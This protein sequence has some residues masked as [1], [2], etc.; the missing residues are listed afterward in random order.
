MKGVL[1]R[2]DLLPPE[3]IENIEE[4]FDTVNHDAMKEV[5]KRGILTGAGPRGQEVVMPNSLSSLDDEQLGDLLNQVSAWC[6]FLEVELGKAESNYRSAQRKLNSMK[7]RIRITL[8][9]DEEGKKLTGPDKDDRVGCDPRVSG[10]DREEL[11]HYTIYRI[12]KA[13]RDQAQMNWE[14]VSRRITI[15]GQ[16]VQRMKRESNVAGVPTHGRTFN[17]RPSHQ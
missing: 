16:E 2:L 12:T 15:R 9:I 14:T 7:A 3:D 5:Y 13:A 17:R 6:G 8:K 4:S 11:F 10:A 1:G